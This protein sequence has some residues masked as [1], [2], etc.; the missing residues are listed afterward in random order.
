MSE[1]LVARVSIDGT[2]HYAALRA[3]EQYE[4]LEGSPLTE[5]ASTGRVV[6]GRDA[7]LLP[8]VTPSKII[9]VGANYPGEEADVDRRFP[10]IFLM[11]PS[12]MIAS[13]EAI[14]LPHVFRSAVA[15]GE[16]AVVMGKR[17]KALK[18]EDVGSYILGYTIAND[19]SG[20]DS[21]LEKVPAAVK[22]GSDGFLPIGPFLNL[23]A[24]LRD[25][26]IVTTVNG[27]PAQSGNTGS[28]I[29]GIRE[30]IAHISSVMTLEPGDVVCM[31]T[32]PPKPTLSPGDVVSI[33]ISEIGTLTNRVVGQ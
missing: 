19:L 30:C 8:P 11:P 28:M 27:T 9:G 20:R 26:C 12:A 16:L 1:S 3:G 18:P 17:A 2:A 22:K 33:T 31:G 32:P 14:V 21:W 24:K 13:G 7:A 10:S 4:L 29:F 23:D 6:R 25:F 15:E 5:L